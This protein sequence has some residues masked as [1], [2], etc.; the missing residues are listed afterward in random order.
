MQTT[1]KW[2]LVP[3]FEVVGAHPPHPLGGGSAP[4]T[5]DCPPPWALGSPGFWVP[6]VARLLKRAT[7][8]LFWFC[9]GDTPHSPLP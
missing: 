5:P 9:G 2:L 8:P 3:D 4:S 1:V 7:R 6:L